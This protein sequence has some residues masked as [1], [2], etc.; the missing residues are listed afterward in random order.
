MKRK[1]LKFIFL[2]WM[3]WSACNPMDDAY[4]QVAK[5]NAA[6]GVSYK[7]SL[8]FTLSHTDYQLLAGETASGASNAA[9]YFDFSSNDEAKVLVPII[10]KKKYPQLGK[11]SQAVVTYD[12]YNPVRFKNTESYTLSSADY[13]AGGFRFGNLSSD[14]DIEKATLTVFGNNFSDGKTIDLTYKFYSGSVNEKTTKV[15]FWGGMWHAP[16]YL[17]RADY[18]AMQ[19]KYADFDNKTTAKSYISTY[20][21]VKFL[22]GNQEG[23]YKAIMYAFYAG[24]SNTDVLL[25]YKF[26][27][28]KWIIVNDIQPTTT[29]FGFN[30]SV[31]EPDNTIAYTMVG[32]DYQAMAQLS[33]DGAGK[34]SLAQYNDFDLSI[35]TDKNV[36]YDL[37]G[38]RLL[39]LFPDA[40]EGQKYLVTYATYSPSGYATVHLELQG[41]K[42]IVIE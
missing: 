14:A 11:G 31:W 6:N 4:N 32:A 19:Q 25:L 33:P 20:M 36:I 42:Y 29:Q 27:G 34:S 21:N 39:Q 30:G 23:D 28:G 22:Y 16:Y 18:T 10:L 41:G 37:I 40:Q 26:V 1:N 2:G 17:L 5:E 7:K 8:T 13:T 9:N 12:V 38:Q 24:G 35:W 3:V 15:F